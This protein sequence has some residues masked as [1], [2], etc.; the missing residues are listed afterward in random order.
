MELYKD[1]VGEDNLH[2]LGDKRECIIVDI[3]D[4]GDIEIYPDDELVGEYGTVKNQKENSNE[5]KRIFTGVVTKIDKKP[6][7]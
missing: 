1:Q 2:H 5:D 3:K 4:D 7:G 6:M